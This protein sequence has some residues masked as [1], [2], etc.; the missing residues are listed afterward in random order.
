VGYE[1]YGLMAE[2]E[3][4][5]ERM[6]RE[7]YHF[8]ITKLGGAMPKPDR[9]KRRSFRYSSKGGYGFPQRCRR[10]ITRAYGAMSC[11]H[12]CRRNTSRSRWLS[13]TTY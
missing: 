7:N 8:S 11:G 5:E 6:G 3:H 13:T 4:I 9:I 1:A 10:S 2:I 12:S